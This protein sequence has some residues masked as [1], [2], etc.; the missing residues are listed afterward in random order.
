MSVGGQ[1]DELSVAQETG[2]PSEP[3]VLT[4]GSQMEDGGWTQGKEETEKQEQ[5]L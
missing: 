5:V 2:S 4:E 1:S 3:R